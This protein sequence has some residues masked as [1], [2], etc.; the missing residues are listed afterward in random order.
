[1][2]YTPSSRFSGIDTFTYTISDN[3]GATDTA[4]VTVIT[5]FINQRSI[6]IE[7]LDATLSED[8]R[9]TIIGSF[10]ITDQSEDKN[11]VELDVQIVQMNIIVENKVKKDWI[12]VSITDSTFN[13]DA[14]VVFGDAIT[15]DYGSVLE[16]PI[17][18]N[19]GEYRVTVEVNIF[20]RGIIYSSTNIL[21]T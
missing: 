7:S 11:S 18:E 4:N 17:D 16:S 13:P 3:D 19:S 14:P 12:P 2:T 20:G 5:N 6:Q 21:N 9:K 10:V 1:M 15:I 8:D